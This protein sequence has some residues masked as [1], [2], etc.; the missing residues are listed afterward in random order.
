MNIA[1][2]IDGRFC[3]TLDVDPSESVTQ[4]TLMRSDKV[5]AALGDLLCLVSHRA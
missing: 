3:D 5:R 2:Q 4:S 1:I